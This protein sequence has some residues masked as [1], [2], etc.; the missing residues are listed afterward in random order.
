LFVSNL[1][2]GYVTFACDFT[3]CSSVQP[4]I[5]VPEAVWACLPGRSLVIS[6]KKRKRRKA[7][8]DAVAGSPRQDSQH[9]DPG[10][11]L[12]ALGRVHVHVHLLTLTEILC[13]RAIFSLR[14]GP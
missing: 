12:H 4:A 10:A 11:K 9:Q 8:P 2:D 3:L 5:A 13:G 7:M 1:T 14:V 6:R